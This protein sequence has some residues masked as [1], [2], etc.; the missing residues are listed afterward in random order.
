MIVEGKKEAVIQFIRGKREV[1]KFMRA[2][3]RL[4][5]PP[6]VFEPGVDM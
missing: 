2:V 6:T 5:P 3:I 4:L 1:L